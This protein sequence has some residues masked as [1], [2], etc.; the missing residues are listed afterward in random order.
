MELS[1]WFF[2]L[3]AL[4]LGWS[5]GANNAS[6]IFGTAVVSK[7]LKF[8]TAA[9]ISGIFVILGSVISG[10]GTTKTLNDLGSVNALAGSFAVA[11]GAGISIILMI[12][13]KLLV[14]S[15][16][17]IV[18][19][20]IGWNLFT[21]SPT[22]YFSLYKILLS[23][24]T[25][26]I[27]AAVFGFLLFKLM[28]ATVLKWKIH[29][30]E[31]DT[32]T[33]FGLILA[34]ALASYSFG[35]N[36]IANVMG[37]FVSSVQLPNLPIAH[38]FVLNGEQQLFLLGGIS[39]AV[40]IF[41]YG[42]Q[43]INTV[44]EDF[45]RISPITGFVAVSA[46]ILVLFLFTSQKLEQFFIR[47]N[48]PPVPLVP[49]STTQAFIGAIIGTGIAKDPHSVNFKV[50]GKIASGW[51]IAP[52]V[53]G[54]ITFVSLFFVQNVF[55]QKVILSE[56]YEL[57]AS[58]MTELSSEG[59]RTEAIGSLVNV[60]FKTKK[61]F[62]VELLQRSRF[63]KEQLYK[64][65]SCSIIDSFYIDTNRLYKNFDISLLTP[66]QLQEIKKQHGEAFNH[67]IDF[68]QALFRSRT[69]WGAAN[70]TLSTIELHKTMTTL[71]DLFR[72][73]A[74]SHN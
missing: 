38:I 66:E 2:I 1:V 58:V 74:A 72:V 29:L 10:G 37:M 24:I 15:A 61:E 51:V 17:V 26:P 59:I 73:S 6:N 34:G 67:K 13:S 54:L 35:A 68:Q 8:R 41:T 28:K 27:I 21:D 57:T 62:R 4:F 20:I 71:E 46:E 16:Q 56:P 48:L 19:A 53:A 14:S 45:N 50:L 9:V 30:L 69:V 55:E 12:R 39:I 5:S 52:A 22:D 23:W 36:N 49:L 11:A 18:G 64:I 47:S 44:S 65:F 33:R 25:S 32:Y 31:F 42:N 70:D 3:S 43:V 60:R 7:M 63:T 40:G